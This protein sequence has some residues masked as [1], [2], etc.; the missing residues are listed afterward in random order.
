M[1]AAVVTPHH[2]EHRRVRPNTQRQGQD[3][4]ARERRI[5][6]KHAYSVSDILDEA[7]DRRLPPNVADILF[8]GF[9][10]AR[11]QSRFAD[12]F[13]AIHARLDLLFHC[14]LNVS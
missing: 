6:S 14:A 5:L 7:F 11:L 8:Q 13:L 2:A 3:C 1:A 4:Y 12:S 10:T 9:Y